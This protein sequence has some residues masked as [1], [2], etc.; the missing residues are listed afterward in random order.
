[1]GKE[2]F[3]Q[4]IFRIDTETSTGFGPSEWTWPEVGTNHYMPTKPS[5]PTVTGPL[6]VPLYSS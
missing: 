3:M 6:H 2:T 4:V 5:L 1:M